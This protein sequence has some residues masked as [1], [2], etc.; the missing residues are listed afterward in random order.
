TAVG[1]IAAA[2]LSIGQSINGNVS[3]AVRALARMD[4]GLG[5]TT[6]TRQDPQMRAW[7]EKG[8]SMTPV[9]D[10]E[11]PVRHGQTMPAMR[12]A[13]PS[14][15]LGVANSAHT[16]YGAFT[17]ADKPPHSESRRAR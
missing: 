5:R 13:G 8:R 14:S 2:S 10:V 4:E 17:P 7:S 16:E 1:P 3:T 9:A 11:R 12:Y 6:A 15:R